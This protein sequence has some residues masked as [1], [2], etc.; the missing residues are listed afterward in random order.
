MFFYIHSRWY[1]NNSVFV[2]LNIVLMSTG[3]TFGICSQSYSEF[4]P[5]LIPELTPEMIPKLTPIFLGCSC[6]FFSASTPLAGIVVFVYDVRKKPSF[7][8]TF[9]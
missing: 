8:K 5:E 6:Q 2:F 4:C 1:I 3:I 7:V 9:S